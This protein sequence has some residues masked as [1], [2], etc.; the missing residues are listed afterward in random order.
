MVF[1]RQEQ[2]ILKSL[3]MNPRMSD[4]M[5]GKQ[6]KVPIRTVSR[7]RK[8]LEECGAISYYLNINHLDKIKA[9]HLYIIKFRMGITKKKLMDEIRQEPK[10][11]TLFTEM[12]Y[13]SH[14]AEVDGHT[15]IIMIVEAMSDEE[16][17]ENFNGKILSLMLKNH[18]KDSIEDINTIRLSDQIRLFHNYLPFINM[19]NGKLNMQISDIY[20]D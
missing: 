5:I 4:N 9:R 3:I 6:T 20:I 1:D 18:G 11:K 16:V 14:Y 13:E 10:L 15:A 19:H 2:L 7:R 12:I 8:K 17:S